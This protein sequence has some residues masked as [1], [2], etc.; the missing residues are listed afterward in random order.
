MLISRMAGG[1]ESCAKS[2][3]ER[4]SDPIIISLPKGPN[5]FVRDRVCN[6]MCEVLSVWRKSAGVSPIGSVG[7]RVR[8]V[9]PPKLIFE[10]VQLG[11]LADPQ[12]FDSGD[13]CEVLQVPRSE[14]LAESGVV[15]SSR[16]NPC[17]HRVLQ[18]G[19]R[20][21]HRSRHRQRR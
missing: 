15:R 12:K 13:L 4:D 8:R 10:L 17:G 19:S 16:V 2:A 6:G 7:P 20:N 11:F 21:P 1:W 14:R 18:T 3:T 9:I 5:I